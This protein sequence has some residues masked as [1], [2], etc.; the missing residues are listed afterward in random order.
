MKL[1][2]SSGQVTVKHRQVIRQSHNYQSIEVEYGIEIQCDNDEAA[3]KKTRIQA[4]RFVED[5]ISKKALEQQRV[6]EALGQKNKG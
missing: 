2:N 3:I 5:A 1:K 4:Q 6:L